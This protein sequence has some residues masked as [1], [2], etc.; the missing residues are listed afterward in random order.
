M[1]DERVRVG[2]C[3]FAED[4]DDYLR[5]LEVVADLDVDLIGYGDG[6]SLWADPY[7]V[8]TLT[9]L[10]APRARLGT[11][12]TNPVTR[13]ASVTASAIA[14]IQQLSG[15]RAFLGIGTGYS[16][17]VPLGLRS[18]T[19]GELEAYIDDVR[20]F[21]AGEVVRRDGRAQRFSWKTERVPIYVAADGPRMQQLAG[22]MGDGAILGNGA[23]EDLI[24]DARRNIEIGAKAAG[25]DPGEIELISLIRVTPAASR[26]AGIESMLWYMAAYVA[27][28][29]RRHPEAKGVPEELLPAIAGLAG[30]YRATEHH[31]HADVNFNASLVDKYGLREWIADQFLVTGTP[32]ECVHRLEHLIAAGATTI[33]VPQIGRDPIAS[34]RQLGGIFE[35]I[36]PEGRQP[37][38]T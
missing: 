28:I 6:Q 18:P 24:R 3:R 27:V 26:D 7:V 15:G 1:A 22:R 9:A 11:I 17:L 35:R 36:R 20:R 5:W 34:T 37:Q 12:I 19:M 31:K 13:V 32:D 21:C 38:V 16:G 29:F 10:H 33:V 30:E 25:R 4:L 23:H 2:V 8:L 14:S